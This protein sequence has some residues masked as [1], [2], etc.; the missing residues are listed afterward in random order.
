M[1]E[2]LSVPIYNGETG[3]G[4]ARISGQEVRGKTGTTNSNSSAWFCGFTG[5]YS[6]S[7]WLGFDSEADGNRG[8]N[9]DSTRC[10]IL[11]QAVMAPAHS[12]KDKKGWN[13]P[14]GITTAAICK[15]SGKLAT[16]ECKH[17]PEGNKVYSEYFVTGTVPKD[18]CTTHVKVE[19]CKKTNLLA[20]ENCKE[21]EEKVFITRPNAETDTKWKSAA[22]AK[23]MVPT[24]VCEECKK[25]EPDK[26][27]GNNTNTNTNGINNLKPANNTTN[28]NT[29]KPTGNTNTNKPNG[30]GNTTNTTKPTG[31]T[32]TSGNKKP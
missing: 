32:T 20:T 24:K 14:S 5:H 9:A 13:K 6:A 28:T 3:G 7:V 30:S 19:V 31:N 18:H 10:A 12:G 8:G 1:Q 25:I 15:V 11:W 2:L 26:P 17:D 23:Y 4:N 22:D 27:D 29:N 16:E 21:K